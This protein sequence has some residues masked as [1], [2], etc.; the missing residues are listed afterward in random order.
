MAAKRRAT[1]G[2][3]MRTYYTKPYPTARDVIQD[4]QYDYISYRIYE[5]GEE[6]F[7][8]AFKT[9]QCGRFMPLN[10]DDNDAWIRLCN[11]NVKLLCSEEWSTPEI[12]HGLTIVAISDIKEYPDQ[13]YPILLFD[14]IRPNTRTDIIYSNGDRISGKFKDIVIDSDTL[15]SAIILTQTKETLGIKA[16]N[17]TIPF[18]SIKDI[19]R[20]EP[21]QIPL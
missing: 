6:K 4:K 8:D 2:G 18:S 1:K 17:I 11:E 7:Y 12:K 13:D 14:F 10:Y 15:E 16:D 19:R 5:N 20:E 21:V 3:R 9:S